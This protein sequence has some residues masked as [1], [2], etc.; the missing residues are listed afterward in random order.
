MNAKL[1]SPKLNTRLL[2]SVSRSFYLSIRL[3]PAKL[4]P[5]IGVAYMLARTSDTIA[6][7][8]SAPASVRLR[9]LAEFERIIKG[10][11]TPQAITNIQRDIRPE[12]PGERNLIDTM[13]QVLDSFQALDGWDWKEIAELMTNII[14]G[15]SMDL[16]TFQQPGLVA[17]LPD[18]NALEDYIYLVAG[19]VGEWWTRLCLSRLPRYS[20]ID[21]GELTELG[22]NFGKGLQLVNILRDLPAD[23]ASGRCYLPESELRNIGTSPEA[24]AGS[25]MEAQPVFDIWEQHA[26]ELLDSGRHYIL[27]ISSRRTRMACY[28]PWRLG[29]ETL[30]LLEQNP[31]LS[32]GT[33][34]KVSRASVRSA[35]FEAFG[36]AFSDR[37]LMGSFA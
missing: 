14:R 36:V 15:Q 12:H 13:P 28:I 6:D 18:A 23:L 29:I 5:A 17:A 27:S 32:T 7:T 3:M 19:C 8:E 21:D 16:E 2:K 33:K 25:P 9:R 37:R 31:P 22:S 24:L 35:L 10:G 26:R 11:A 1:K 4:R 30:D 34:A 20:K